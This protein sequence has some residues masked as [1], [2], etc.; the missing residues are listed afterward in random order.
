MAAPSV[1]IKDILVAAGIGTFAG[2]SGW[3]IYVSQEPKNP[4]SVIT[5]YDSG[6]VAP[7]PKWLFDEPTVQIRIRGSE[8]AYVAAYAKAQAIKDA[9]LGLTPQTVSGTYY[10]GVQMVGDINHIGYDDK[11]RPLFTTNWR[12][13]REPASGTYRT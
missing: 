8:M 3:G 13:F 7:N 9:L 1:D 6:G 12:I 4:D 11:S 5:I 10:V 2:T